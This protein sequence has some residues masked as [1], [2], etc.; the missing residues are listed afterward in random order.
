MK[1]DL[2]SHVL[3]GVDHGARDWEMSL[4]MLAKSARCGVDAIIATPHYLPWKKDDMA[5]TIRELCKEAEKRLQDAYGV[6]MTI[7]PGNEAY[8]STETVE[9]LKAGK[10]LT[11]AGSRYV[12]IEFEPQ[13]SYGTLCKA[14]RDLRFHSYLPI[15]AHVERYQ[16]LENIERLKELKEMGALLQVNVGSFQGGLFDAQSNKVKKWLKKGLIDFVASDMHD[17]E[18]RPPLSNDRLE[19]FRAKLDSKYQ[20]KLLY[21][22]AQKILDS[23]KE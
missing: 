16:C 3:V 7:Y 22:N 23:I 1:I 20:D 15:F 6:S 21:G 2:H 12:L 13:V 17:M 9:L 11:L 10:I 19:W 8:Y 18:E 14:A 4:K 5:E